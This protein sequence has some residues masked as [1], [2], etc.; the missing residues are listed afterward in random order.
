MN[1]LNTTN[2]KDDR[3][4][5]KAL[6]QGNED[7]FEL[8]FKKYSGRVYFV[9]FQYLNDREDTLEI[10]QEAFF[11]IWMNHKKIKPDLPFIPYLTRIAKNL[12]INR[13]KRK[14]IEN[15]YIQTLESVHDKKS[16]QTEDQVL[17]CEVREIVNNLIEQFPEKRKEVFLLSRAKGLTNKEIA[18]KLDISESTVENHI[19]SALKSLRIDLR[20]FGYLGCAIFLLQICN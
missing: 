6:K 2:Q 4:L 8:L 9:A 16:I 12:I 7:A 13:S 18:E 10:V 3:F 5:L 1:D 14:L 15:A 17:F 11:K 20:T 19:N